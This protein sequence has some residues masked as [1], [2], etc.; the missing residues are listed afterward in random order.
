MKLFSGKL[1]VL[2]KAIKEVG[3]IKLQV[4]GKGLKKGNKGLKTIKTN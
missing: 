2:V 4:T 3:N 1:A